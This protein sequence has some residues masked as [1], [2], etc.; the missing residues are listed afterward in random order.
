MNNQEDN[1]II[2]NKNDCSG[3]MTCRQ[4]C[5]YNAIDVVIDDEGFEYPIR[6]DKCVNCGLC[7][8]ICPSLNIV[9]P[10]KEYKQKVY[11]CKHKD[12]D[13]IYKS[14]SGGMFTAIANAFCDE[15][16]AIFGVEFDDKFNAF[17]SYITDIS[18]IDKYRRSKYVQSS[19]G[20]SYNDARRLLEE[21]KKVLFT[22]TPC[23]IAG[24]KTFLN[25]NYENLLTVDIICHGTPSSK[26]LNKYIQ[27]MEKKNKSRIVDVKFREKVFKH[28]RWDSKC[29]KIKF[30]SNKSIIEN[31]DKNF[32][33][34]GFQTGLFYRPSCYRCKYANPV[35]NSDITIADCWGLQKYYPELNAHQGI[36]MVVINSEKGEKVFNNF[37]TICSCIPLD[38]DYAVKENRQ[39]REP[40]QKNNQRDFFYKNIDSI[41][42]NRLI[43]KC[44]PPHRI[45]H[46][47]SKMVPESIKR[48]IRR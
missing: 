4:I 40:A 39:F 42:F 14:S 11:A 25:K 45:R 6:N 7:T 20:N 1:I 29:I 2:C 38:D 43:N 32:Y 33:L 12:N 28:D 46:I 36:S 18:K 13:I 41:K 5:P 19:I 23:Q 16:Y 22:G 21:G 9:K 30:E 31:G 27:Y 3:C 10:Q 35:R 47:A 48:I 17:H 37:K 26:V 8:K 15:N 44:I 24:L 34:K